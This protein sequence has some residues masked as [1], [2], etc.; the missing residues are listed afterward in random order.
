M[1]EIFFGSKLPETDDKPKNICCLFPL[2]QK[3]FQHIFFSVFK[4]F[5]KEYPVIL[6]M[7]PK[8]WTEEMKLFALHV[9]Y[10]YKI[11]IYSFLSSLFLRIRKLMRIRIGQNHADPEPWTQR[12]FSFPRGWNLQ[13]KKSKIFK[14]SFFLGR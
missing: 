11:I 13:T 12:Y 10:S 1:Y 6:I 3:W 7:I 4:A 14:L 8:V 2:M 9:S 5:L